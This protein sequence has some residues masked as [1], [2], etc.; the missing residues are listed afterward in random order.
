MDVFG[1]LKNLS[2]LIK[3][4]P[5]LEVDGTNAHD[6]MLTN[7][8]ELSSQ[9][10]S[11]LYSLDQAKA[12]FIAE[13][14]DM[15]NY[16]FYTCLFETPLLRRRGVLGPPKCKTSKSRSAA[17]GLLANL[18]TAS[19]RI[20]L[21]TTELLTNQ[22]QNLSLPTSMQWR[23]YWPA[24]LTRASCGYTGLKNQGA[25]C[26][27]NSLLQQ[28]YMIPSFRQGILDLKPNEIHTAPNTPS[29]PLSQG[30]FGSMVKEGSSCSEGSSGTIV[31]QLQKMFAFLR[32]SSKLFYDT[33]PM[34][35]AYRN[36]SGEI[37]QL[38][39]QMDVEEFMNQIF[40]RLESNLKDTDHPSLLC[41]HFG[42]KLIQ[43]II[44][45][46]C[47]HVSNRTEAFYAV[48]CTV[49]SKPSVLES[50]S[51]FVAGETLDGDNKY[52]CEQCNSKV[53]AIKRVCIQ[54]LPPILVLHLKRID[55]NMETFERIKINDLC[56]FPMEINMKRY[57]IEGIQ[58]LDAAK[59]YGD[60][61][62][63]P[64]GLEI[65]PDVY[66]QVAISSSTFS[67]VHY[68]YKLCILHLFCLF[69]LG[70]FFILLRLSPFR[71]LE[72]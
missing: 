21:Q 20:F 33:K 42:G 15:T 53:V 52:H 18:C 40:D 8:L 36:P 44:S 57:T 37:M 69:F 50:L 25:T 1:I 35:D 12:C 66:Y 71:Y 23:S 34:C 54:C 26:Y 43:Q 4:H 60:K 41:D 31:E 56:E 46:D 27:M 5:C 47:V 72:I 61:Q 70:G 51:L 17:F 6:E 3:K 9:I 29:V 49:K 14:I 32:E 64:V 55:F 45:K 59:K 62:Y 65:R 24:D 68:I 30:T 19:T 48:Q 2:G 11:A 39:V 38:Q 63:A 58:E 7:I 16:V 10:I 13:S 22:F 28:L 67:F